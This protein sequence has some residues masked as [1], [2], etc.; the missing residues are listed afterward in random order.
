MS[1][2]NKEAQYGTVVPG[3]RTMAVYLTRKDGQK[4]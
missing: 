2:D 1:Q 3:D 4:I